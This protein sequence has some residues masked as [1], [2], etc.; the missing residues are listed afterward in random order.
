VEAGGDSV[1]GRP[2]WLFIKLDAHG[3]YPG[4]T[5][6]VLGDAT[7]SFVKELIQG[8]AEPRN[9]ALCLRARDGKHWLWPR[10]TAAKVILATTAIIVIDWPKTHHC[11]GTPGFEATSA[12]KA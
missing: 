10:A 8:A 7:R 4:D 5:E 9:T 2:D 3:M 12:V 6:T 11:G 1:D